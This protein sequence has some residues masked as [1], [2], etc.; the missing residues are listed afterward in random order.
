MSLAMS[1]TVAAL[2]ERT[3]QRQR[4][5]KMQSRIHA[6]LDNIFIIQNISG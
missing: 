4:Q 1:A 6:F 3:R 2:A 5:T